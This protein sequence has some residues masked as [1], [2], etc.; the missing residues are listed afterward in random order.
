MRTPSRTLHN[1]MLTIP[2]FVAAILGVSPRPPLVVGDED[3]PIAGRGCFARP[4]LRAQRSLIFVSAA[5]VADS[6]GQSESAR[7]IE[8]VQRI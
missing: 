4:E 8:V 5:E 3:V 1:L 6:G 7:R 2:V